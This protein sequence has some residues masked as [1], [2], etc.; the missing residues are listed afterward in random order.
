MDS[1]RGGL[2]LNVIS[3]TPAIVRMVLSVLLFAAAFFL[4]QRLTFLLRFSPYDRTTIWTPGA[5]LLT[6]LL[7]TP[8]RRWWVY[9]AG[10]C[11]GAFA[12]YQGDV[13]IPPW[14]A[15][16]A[17]QFHF[18]AVVIGVWGVSRFSRDPLFGDPAALL[19]FVVAV[20]VIVPIATTTPVDFVRWMQGADDVWPV[21]LRSVLCVALGGVIATP[22]FTLTLA[23]SYIW[24]HN[25][26]WR[27]VV[28]FISL[29]ALMLAVGYIA[30]AQP[31]EGT[32]PAM[33]Y[34]PAPFLLW[35]A[36]RF[37]LAGV[38]WAML[39]LAYQS[40][41][42][43]IHGYGP[44]SSQ[45]SADNVLQLQLFLLANSLPLMFLAVVIEQRTRAFAILAQHEQQVRSQYAQLRT[46]YQEAPVG[47][48]FV[49]TQLRFVSANDRLAEMHGIPA[50]AHVGRALRQ[51]LPTLADKL[52]PLYQQAIDSGKPILGIEVIG[53]TSAPSEAR[54]DWLLGHYPVKDPQGAVFGVSI[55]GEEITE[56]KR[57]ERLREEL[58]HASRV[59]LLGEFTASIAHEINQPL[60]AI[61]SNADAA[62][63]LL[64]AASPS[65]EEVRRILA[66]IQRDSVRASEVIGRL[67][68]L[69]RKGEMDCRPVHLA[70]IVRETVSL[71]SGEARRRGI[72]VE[73]ELAE[74]LPPVYGN[75]IHLQQVLINLL[76][77]GMEAI[78]ETAGAGKILI[79][80]I[81]DGQDVLVS[82]TDS[83][84][85]ISAN[86]ISQVFD[87]FFSTKHEGMGMGLT[88]SRTL[89]ECQGGRI[90]AENADGGGATFRFSLPAHERPSAKI[91]LPDKVSVS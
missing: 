9:Y 50:E 46:I 61:L 55:V 6:A 86:G 25:L 31:V 59:T 74:N 19:V 5:L 44:F 14:N 71:I 65:L 57:A 52:E 40:T 56:R 83:G 48:A 60:A 29:V 8:P 43:A 2:P 47:L 87:H 34:V 27:R 18:G 73:T 15:L 64:N 70:E 77:N 75:R 23:N 39:A 84:P 51:M 24:I 53:N 1:V 30:Y 88:I 13:T 20:G 26:S 66:D 17:A 38:C 81:Q 89:V 11:L 10:L 28:E 78:S 21:A 35:A 67:R 62:E 4:L 41:W 90:W 37:H 7:L 91:P 49:D 58:T 3:R 68:S 82:V 16:L 33:L 69:L 80:T 79:R 22:A 12:A 63:L 32:R 45:E 42:G 54:R 76:V 85:G 36:L 72:N